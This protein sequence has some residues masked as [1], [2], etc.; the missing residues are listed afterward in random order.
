MKH[1][2]LWSVELGV[3]MGPMLLG[4]PYDQLLS[5]LRRYPVDKDA[6]ALDKFGVLALPQIRTRLLF[7]ETNPR[8]LQRIEVEDERLRFGSLT[9]IGKRV[10]EIVGIFKATRK[11]TLWGSDQSMLDVL[12]PSGISDPSEVSRKLLA[13]GTLWITSLGLGM[14]LCDGLIAK[15]QLCDPADAPCEGL[16]PWT[17]EQQRL[18]EVREA[19]SVRVSTNRKSI[20]RPLI[21]SAMFGLVGFVVWYGVQLQRR[22]DA[23]PDLP[24]VVVAVDPPP[25][26]VFPERVTV[27]FKDFENNDR[28]QTLDY[29]QFYMTPKVGDEVMV[30]YLP[31]EPNN[32]RG[33]VGFRDVGFDAAFP[34]GIGILA[35]G[36]AIQLLWFGA[37]MFMGRKR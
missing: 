12:D 8:T 21:Q 30:R 32:V 37:S 20:A 11:E 19:P 13:G 26:I 16:G 34:Y 22:W 24:A 2:E 33:P 10:H 27:I 17:K 9:V 7:S 25:P 18:S 3:G 4:L 29:R 23:A 35:I 14:T 15:V 31:D 5:V 6:L 28:Q 1:D 36:T